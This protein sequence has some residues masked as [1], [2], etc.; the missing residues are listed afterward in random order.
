MLT[1]LKLIHVQRCVIKFKVEALFTLN[2]K[3]YNFNIVLEPW[4]FISFLSPM[5][6]LLSISSLNC[7][8]THQ[9]CGIFVEWIN[10]G[11]NSLTWKTFEIVIINNVS[12]H[13]SIT[14]LRIP[15]YFLK[16]YM[17]FELECLKY[18]AVANTNLLR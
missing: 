13:Q 16:N 12:Y 18:C 9:W 17:M 1:N 7:R 5:S 11:D 2:P 8:W 15:K 10:L 4:W 3:S 14:K 6:L